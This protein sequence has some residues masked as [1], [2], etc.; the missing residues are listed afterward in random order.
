MQKELIS[1]IIPVY[2]VEKY[3]KECVESVRQQTYKN[4]EI[5]LVND[6]STDDS[7]IICDELQ[8]KDSRIRVVHKKNGGVSAAR[9]CGIKIAKGQ[10][11]G[12]LDSDDV[13]NS[14]MYEVLHDHMIQHK[15]LMAYC[16]MKRMYG[17]QKDNEE[18]PEP[19]V[20]EGED[21]YSLKAHFGMTPRPHIGKSVCDK[22]FARE[23]VEG[24]LFDERYSLGEDNLF[25][26][27]V[28]IKKPRCVYVGQALY[29]YRDEREGNSK[30]GGVISDKTFSEQIPVKRLIISLLN[31]NKYLDIVASEQTKFYKE[32][33][34]Y[35]SLITEI[36][37][38]KQRNKCY[39]KLNI[40]FKEE[41][42]HIKKTF[43]NT[44]VGWKYKLK[45]IC[46]F[47]DKRLFEIIESIICRKMYIKSESRY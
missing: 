46:W 15:S 8:T 43:R 26:T 17:E 34:R 47:L 30:S 6:G 10:M 38:K 5:I 1:I 31:K 22:L 19:I 45:Y 25:I 27:E 33:L 14:R 28:L 20:L 4:I 21:G 16:L 32:L 36:E 37:D 23:L 39:E 9:N 40:I 13:I 3:L 24:L 18:I 29:Y 44:E 11:I 2:N 12:F 42:Q 35:H 7:G 41:R